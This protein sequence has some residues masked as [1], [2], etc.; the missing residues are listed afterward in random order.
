MWANTKFKN[1]YPTLTLTPTAAATPDF[2]A[3]IAP[4]LRAQLEATAAF[5]RT[6]A[7]HAEEKKDEEDGAVTTINMSPQEYNTTL[8][9]CGLPAGSLPRLLPEW[10]IDCAVKGQDSYRYTIIRRHI[11]NHFRYEDAEV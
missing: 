4:L 6:P 10:M 9:M 8:Q 5:H 7:A 3:L 1:S 11:M 2:A